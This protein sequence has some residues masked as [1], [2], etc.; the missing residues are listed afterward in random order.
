M[1]VDAGFFDK[2][3]LT[4]GVVEAMAWAKNFNFTQARVK[5]DVKRVHNALNAIIDSPFENY[6]LRVR[7]FLLKNTLLLLWVWLV[8]MSIF[9][10]ILLLGF[11]YL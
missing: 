6:Q 2:G 7:N 5:T 3:D 9:W 8:K 4:C 1:D 10:H 11:L